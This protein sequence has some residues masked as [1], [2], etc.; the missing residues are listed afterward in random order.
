MADGETVR[1]LA[2]PV[3]ELAA[4]GRQ[5]EIEPYPPGQEPGGARLA[6]GGLEPDAESERAGRLPAPATV[7]SGSAE[8][9]HGHS[10]QVSADRIP[11]G[12]LR[13]GLHEANGSGLRGAGTRALGEAIAPPGAGTGL[14]GAEDRA[15]RGG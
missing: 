5:G 10:A 13:G 12:A 8:G 3:S 1:Q 4:D 11:P 9:H 7:A 2:G 6:V 14:R 15:A